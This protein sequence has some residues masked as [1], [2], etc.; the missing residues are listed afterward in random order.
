MRHQVL[1][2]LAGWSDGDQT[3]LNQLIPLVYDE[4]RRLA[5]SHLRRQGLQHSLQ[6]TAVVHEAYLR[7]VGQQEVKF[8]NRAQFFGLAAQVIRAILV[9]HARNRQ[10][11]KRGGGW[12]KVPLAD[13]LEVPQPREMDLIALNHALEILTTH[14]PQQSRVVELRYFGGLT[15]EETA[16]FLKISPAT[17]KRDWN[18]ARAWLHREIGKHDLGGP[19]P[20][21]SLQ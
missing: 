8:E 4:L 17:V 5:A 9:D 18:L 3:A 21:T 2:L 6:P 12:L 19:P 1:E 11:A 15:I 14:D 16:R 10:A 20:P 7:L 13:A